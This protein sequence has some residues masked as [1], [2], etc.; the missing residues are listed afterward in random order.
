MTNAHK[1][2]TGTVTLTV[3]SHGE[4]IEITSTNPVRTGATTSGSQGGHGLVGM[5]E[6]AA[7]A[8]GTA[9]VAEDGDTFTVLATLRANGGQVR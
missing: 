3:A 4:R 6:R 9:D 1:Y 7:A 2:G 5:R 8:G